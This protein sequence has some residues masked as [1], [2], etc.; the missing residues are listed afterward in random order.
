MATRYV[1]DDTLREAIGSADVDAEQFGQVLDD[2]RAIHALIVEEPWLTEAKLRTSAEETG[3][4]PDRFNVARSVLESSARIFAVS[5][6][7]KQIPEQEP[8]PNELEPDELSPQV[9][10]AAPGEGP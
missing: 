5:L 8:G 7:E 3:I 10:H 4:D 1:T 2:A 9:E 6:T